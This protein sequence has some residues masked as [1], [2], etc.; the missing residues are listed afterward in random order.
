MMQPAPGASRLPGWQVVRGST[1][2]S[3]APGPFSARLDT[4]VATAPRFTI[5][6]SCTLAWPTVSS[7][8][9]RDGLACSSARSRAAPPY[10]GRRTTSDRPAPAIL[11]PALKLPARV[12]LKASC[13]WQVCPMASGRAPPQPLCSSA[14]ST[15]VVPSSM[16]VN[17]ALPSLRSVTVC[18][19]GASPTCVTPNDT[20]PGLAR[21]NGTLPGRPLPARTTVERP[22]TPSCTIVSVPFDAP[23]V[24][25]SKRSAT[26]Q[27]CPLASTVPG[28]H[29]LPAMTNGGALAWMSVTINGS[30]L[31]LASVRLRSAPG[32]PTGLVPKSS[33][34]GRTVTTAGIRSGARPSSAMRTGVGVPSWPISSAPL[35]GPPAV[36]V[37][38][39]STVQTLKRGTSAPQLLA[40]TVKSP[41]VRTANAPTP[42][43]V[44]VPTVTAST[45]LLLPT[46]VSGKLNAS[47]VLPR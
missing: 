37:K 46:A 22:P 44:L 20:A 28:A 21:S 43:L 7:K 3:V 13:N 11:N 24:V 47:G 17:G 10:S 45:A 29:E 8:G 30:A 5:T 40:R 19:T 33:S 1:A 27:R 25:G 2:N 23:A 39:T 41:S 32:K 38:A 42:V 34:R 9:R 26:V 6:N 35:R 4:R 14:K 18:R 31:W 16:L 36:G 15:P 12:G